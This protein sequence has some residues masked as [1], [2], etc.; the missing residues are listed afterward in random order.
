MVRTDLTLAQQLCQAVHAAHEAGIRFGTPDRVSA[1]VVCAL[2]DEAALRDALDRLTFHGIR[3]TA[4]HEPDL[5]GRMTA[6]ATEPL[7]RNRRNFLSRY[8][9]WR[10]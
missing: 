2:P 9:L 7:P 3:A 8:P 5:G 10:A 4:F 6:L 1:V